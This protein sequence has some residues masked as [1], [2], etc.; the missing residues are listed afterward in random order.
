MQLSLDI[1]EVVQKAII[2]FHFFAASTRPENQNQSQMGIAAD[3][4]LDEKIL[5]NIAIELI[6]D[7][8]QLALEISSK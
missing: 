5:E 7:Q 2:R 6:L 1:L 8:I 4:S 3:L